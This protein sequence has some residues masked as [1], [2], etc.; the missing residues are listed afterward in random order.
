MLQIL[1]ISRVRVLEAG[2]TP[3]PNF[4]GS[5]PGFSSVNNFHASVAKFEKSL[6]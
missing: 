5:T 3:P 2:R 1:V 6:K 4:S